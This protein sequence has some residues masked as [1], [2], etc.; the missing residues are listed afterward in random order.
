[1]TEVGDESH[2]SDITTPTQA[3]KSEIST[4]FIFPSRSY[5]VQV[6]YLSSFIFLRLSRFQQFANIKDAIPEWDDDEV[7]VRCVHPIAE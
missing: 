3:D 4:S 6:S 5:D 7:D 2:V 1:M